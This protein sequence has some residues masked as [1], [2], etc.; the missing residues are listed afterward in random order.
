[1]SGVATGF[2]NA[3]GAFAASSL[4]PLARDAGDSTGLQATIAVSAVLAIASVFVLPRQVR[5]ST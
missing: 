1:L 4:L 5:V 3:V 2:G